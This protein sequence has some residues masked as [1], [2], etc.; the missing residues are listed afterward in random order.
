[1]NARARKINEPDSIYFN[2]K[3]RDVVEIFLKNHNKLRLDRSI[4]QQIDQYLSY[5]KD[6][7]IK[8][9]VEE[10]ADSV[11][12]EL[13]DTEADY[14]KRKNFVTFFRHNMLSIRDELYDEFKEFITDS[15]FDLASR[16]AVSTYEGMEFLI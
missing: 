12:C 13:I 8:E 7:K 16:K 14:D 15:E 1:M 11:M 5:Q 2:E 10:F 6:Q 3:H 9:A 4:Q